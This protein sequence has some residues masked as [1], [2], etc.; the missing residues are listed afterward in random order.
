MLFSINT[1]RC[2]VGVYFNVEGVFVPAAHCM[3]RGLNLHAVFVCLAIGDFCNQS[4]PLFAVTSILNTFCI[5][6]T[7]NV[8]GVLLVS[9]KV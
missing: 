4:E 5:V 7:R 2:L 8:Q 1:L 3:V 9:A 6:L